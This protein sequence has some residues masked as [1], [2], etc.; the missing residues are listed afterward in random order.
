MLGDK[1]LEYTY[2]SLG[3][4]LTGYYQGKYPEKEVTFKCTK[5]ENN[6][7]FNEGTFLQG[8]LTKKK[9]IKI[10]GYESEYTETETYDEKEMIEVLRDV[11]VDVDTD[12]KGL[13]VDYI[14]AL[15]RKV[16]IHLKEK[17]K[18]DPVL[19]MTRSNPYGR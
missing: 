16:E 19:K 5:I 2:D 6:D 10:R 1:K 12:L 7:Y 13:D 15:D 11:I 8:K 18:K 14:N 3:N 9:K 17:T 4:L